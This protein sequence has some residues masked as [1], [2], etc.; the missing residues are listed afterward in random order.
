MDPADTIPE[1]GILHLSFNG[2]FYC[3]GPP[4]VTTH[5]FYA[6]FV[7]SQDIMYRRFTFLR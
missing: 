7:N 3:V 2:T 4:S 5:L 1:C 6:F